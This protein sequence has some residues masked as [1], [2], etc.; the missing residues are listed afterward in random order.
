MVTVEADAA[1]NS[2]GSGTPGTAPRPMRADAVKNRALILE[3]AEAVFAEEG[4]TVPIDEVARRA[5]V[6]VGTLYRH[7]PTKEHLFEAVVMARLERLLET[8]KHYGD[9]ANPGEA[10]FLFLREF[11]TQAAEKKDL[12]DALGSAGIDFKSLSAATLDEMLASIDALL[13]RAVAVGTVRDDV[14]VHEVVGLV[15][16]A[17]HTGGHG[18]LNGDALQRMI[19]VVIDG[20]KPRLMPAS[21]SSS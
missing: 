7:F 10:F 1:D 16:G 13:T 17:C 6:G 9:A 18:E 11:A 14:T 15:T 5:G 21:N 8:A 3:A 19:G 20:L 12:I 4:V 2:T